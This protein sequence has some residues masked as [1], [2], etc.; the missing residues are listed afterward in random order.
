MYKNWI[1]FSV[2]A[3]LANVGKVLTVK[4][5]CGGIDSRVVVFCGRVVSAGVLLPVMLFSGIGFPTDGIFWLVIV[6]TSLMTA[7]ASVAFTDAVKFGK[8]T[9]VMPMQAAVPVFSLLTL[10]MFWKELPKSASIVLMLLSMAAV[11]W[12]LYADSGDKTSNGRMVFAWLSLVSAVLFGVC[13][14]L[15]RVAVSRLAQGALAY[16][17]CW[18]LF[19]ALLMGAEVWR[20]RNKKPGTVTGFEE[21]SPQTGES[22]NCLRFSQV[23]PVLAVYSAAALSGFF[24]QQYAVQLSQTIPGAVV[25]VKSIGMLYL[26]IVVLVQSL[27]LT[28]RPKPMTLAAGISAIVLSILLV[29]S[30]V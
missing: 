25:N 23:W 28:E 2:L 12:T 27:T 10:W 17:A 6:A 5:R 4:Y 9:V 30:L 21:Q 14:I 24:F 19:S 26:P 7:V 8:L 22:G 18:N 11:A 1:L 13:T 29:R 16:S 20:I 15:D 3:M